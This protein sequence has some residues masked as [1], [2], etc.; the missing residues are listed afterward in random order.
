MAEGPVNQFRPDY[1]IAPGYTLLEVLN[2]VGM[3]QAQ[4]ADRTGRPRKTINE[5]VKGKSQITPDTAIQLERALGVP[6]AFWNNLERQYRETVARLAETKRLETRIQWMERFP[7][8]AMARLGWISLH[9]SPVRQLQEVLNYFG[10][11][12]PEAWHEVWD[13]MPVAFRK[14]PAFEAD[15][16]AVAAWLRQGELQA[17][18][19]ESSPYEEVRFKAALQSIRGKTTQPPETFVPEVKEVAAGAGVVVLFIRE[20]PKIRASGATRWLTPTK[21]LVQLSLRYKTDD[22]LW[23][24]FFHESAHILLHGK[25]EVFLEGPS[26]TSQKE[27]EA[28]EFAA[29]FLV[30]PESLQEFALSGRKS[31]MAI[32]EFADRLGVSPGIVVG[33]LQHIGYLPHSHCNDLKQ[34]FQWT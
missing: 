2:S 16:G 23:F 6:A 9:R 13:S 25:T 5:I 7:L 26:V 18:Q 29:S 4:L 21:A 31:R 24:T 17:L 30:P 33:Q 8:G 12:T 32:I 20:L 14:S 28:N 10:V 27:S 34:H 1:A 15:P 11:A 22:H 3:T 19:V